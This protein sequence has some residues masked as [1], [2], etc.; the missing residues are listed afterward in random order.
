MKKFTKVCLI[1]AAVFAALG[2]GF[3]SAGIVNGA[4]WHEFQKE[5]NSGAYSIGPF[6]RI[7]NK[8]EDWEEHFDDV[9]DDIDDDLDEWADE[10]WEQEEAHHT[11][12]VTDLTFDATEVEELEVEL[13]YGEICILPTTEK[14]FYVELEEHSLT[15]V[16]CTQSGKKLKI[17]S[18]SRKLKDDT[19]W[20]Y[21]PENASI[22]ELSVDVDAGV[23]SL[24]NLSAQKLEVKIGA[25]QFMGEGT[26]TA[27][28]AELEVGAGELSMELLSCG[29]V[30]LECGLGSLNV[31]LEGAKEEYSYELQCGMGEIT[32]GDEN[33]TS[34]GKKQKIQNSGSRKSLKA[35]CG[36]GEIDVQFTE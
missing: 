16:D 13:K 4:T 11:G 21:I 2:V 33:Y 29:N 19:L 5:M 23:V 28:E 8:M 30:D 3:V 22:Q 26:L 24:E 9:F 35:D 10:D 12:S 27:K 15:E 6:F 14:E 20:V 25:G 7:A 36:M 18:S 32:I 34:L 17:E 31:M 1:L